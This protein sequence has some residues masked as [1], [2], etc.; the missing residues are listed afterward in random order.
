MEKII[1]SLKGK[2]RVNTSDNSIEVFDE[3]GVKM[4]LKVDEATMAE[5]KKHFPTW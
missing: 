5:Y 3:Y 1:E 2:V 4:R